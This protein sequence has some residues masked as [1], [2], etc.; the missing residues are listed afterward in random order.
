MLSIVP[1]MV[2]QSFY[3]AY[4]KY[5]KYMKAATTKPN[6]LTSKAVKYLQKYCV[7]DDLVKFVV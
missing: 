6:S 3:S 2:Y 4:M 1:I 5:S 7:V